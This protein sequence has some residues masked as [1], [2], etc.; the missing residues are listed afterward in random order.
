MNEIA[1]KHHV[2]Q[3]WVAVMAQVRSRMQAQQVHPS[4]TV[5]LLPYAQLMPQ[6]RQ[7]WLRSSAGDAQQTGFLPRFETTMNWSR[8]LGGFAPAADD[9][10]MDAARDLL[11]ATSLLA[12][13]GLG[14]H[15]GVLAARLMACAWSLAR[16]AAAVAPAERAA[17]GAQLGSTLAAALDSPLLALEAATAR[18]ALAWA[19]SSGYASDPVFGAEPDL[20][21]L[22]Q[23]FQS[24]PLTPALQQRLGDKFLLLS[25]ALPCDTSLPASL[26]AA[27][28]LHTAL[29]AEDEA[30]RA[31][32]CVLAHLAAGR[33][34]VALVAQDR[35]LT[36]RVHAMLGQTG[37]TLSDE[38][39]WKLSTTRAAASLMSLLRAQ[40]WDAST[41]AVLDWLK[42]APVFDAQQLAQAETVWRRKGVREWSG[43][44]LDT[45]LTQQVQAL[46]ERLQAGRPLARWLQDLRSVLQEAGQ[47]TVLEQDEAGAAVLDVLRLREGA[48]AEF[49]DLG[50]RMAAGEFRAWVS[51]TLEEQSFVPSHAANAQ[52]VILPLS[53]LL[54]R[55]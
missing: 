16:V 6:A 13:A 18:I 25:L 28:A 41:D 8:S 27:V 21:V 48:Q 7:A 38:T 39:G 32:A 35:V 50:A 9:L 20:L 11:T 36:R 46:R 54:G 47:W 49:A 30:Q 3:A 23:G 24:E 40:V 22:L 15:S 55:Y 4:R 26:S 19:A 10:R 43:V 44:A 31:A 5:V 34:P 52:V 12:R 45:D 17:W 29:D 1:K 2:D 42:N 14:A 53:Q 33:S 37:V 51:Q